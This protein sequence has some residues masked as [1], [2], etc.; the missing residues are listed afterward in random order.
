M[1]ILA[2]LTLW[3]LGEMR[4]NVLWSM[5]HEIMFLA[6]FA[7]ALL[8]GRRRILLL[9][10]WGLSPLVMDNPLDLRPHLVS[11]INAVARDLLLLFFQE[12]DANFLFLDGMAAG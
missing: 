7:F 10:A 11:G 12:G 9:M 4:P 5:R 1:A 6:L 3:S 8:G 2:S